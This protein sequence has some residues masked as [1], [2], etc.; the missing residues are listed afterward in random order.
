MAK[1][2][3]SEMMEA[4]MRGREEEIV[5]EPIQ[6]K[7]IPNPPVKEPELISGITINGKK[8][9]RKQTKSV[10]LEKEIWDKLERIAKDNN[11]SVS[12]VLNQILEQALR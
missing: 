10:N 11:L 3:F 2:N 4:S 6:A 1:K 12:S 5:P 8:Y 9:S 7:E